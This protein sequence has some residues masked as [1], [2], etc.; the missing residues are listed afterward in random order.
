M[1][2]QKKYMIDD[3][4]LRMDKK[5]LEYETMIKQYQDRERK[6]QKDLTDA[7]RA[8]DTALNR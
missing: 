5:L 7:I 1:T 3:K 2:L 6:L 4:T 8:K